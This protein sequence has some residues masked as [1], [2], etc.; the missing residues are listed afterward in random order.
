MVVPCLSGRQAA[1]EKVTP[2]D[3]PQVELVKGLVKRL[4]KGLVKEL[5]ERQIQILNLI[6]SN[7]HITKREMAKRIGISTTAIDK[8]IDT[9]KEKKLIERKGGRKE[10]Y[11]QIIDEA[12]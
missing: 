4:A 8:Y 11:W 1:I 10:G 5:S 3:T 12:E 7:N 9:L 6:E 2:Q